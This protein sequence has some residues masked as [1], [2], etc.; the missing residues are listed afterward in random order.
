M[1]RN[2]TIETE[3]VCVGHWNV[4]VFRIADKYEVWNDGGYANYRD[5]VRDA[6]YVIVKAVDGEDEQL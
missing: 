1:Y 6:K 3:K 2:H 5:A 4:A